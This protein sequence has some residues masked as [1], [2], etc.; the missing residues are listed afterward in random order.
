MQLMQSQP[1]A[2]GILWG[3]A[4]RDFSFEFSHLLNKRVWWAFL[5]FPLQL[6]SATS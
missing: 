6:H 1:D 2:A 3:L 4:G 5:L